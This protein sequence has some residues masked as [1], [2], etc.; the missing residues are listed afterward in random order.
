MDILRRIIR[1][2]QRPIVGLSIFALVFSLVFGAQATFATHDISRQNSPSTNREPHDD[3][4]EAFEDRD[5]VVD[6]NDEAVSSNDDDVVVEA[7]SVAVDRIHV[8]GTVLEDVRMVSGTDRKHCRWVNGG[9]NSGHDANGNLNWFH[10][11]LRAKICKNDNSPTGWVKVA[12]GSTGRKCF[13]PFKP[14]GQPPGK[15]VKGKVIMVRSFER[16]NLKV[17]AVADVTVRGQKE[18]PDGSVISGRASARATEKER[19]NQSML[20]GGRGNHE[21][22][23]TQMKQDVFSEAKSR[24]EAKLVLD[25]GEQTETKVKKAVKEEEKQVIDEDDEIIEEPE[26]VAKEKPETI[27]ESDEL[28]ASQPEEQ[29]VDRGKAETLPDTGPGSILATF[30]GA[31][32]LSGIIYSFV[33]RRFGL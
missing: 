16:L 8:R 20:S 1:M 14:N 13:N 23:R 17:N 5:Q 31:S 33:V 24:A 29:I 22:L 3:P 15:V 27:K 30:I 19:I 2:N 25:C 6:E 21:R 28:V 32:S 11:S 9:F 4:D 12:G 7:A 10:D 26:V 18:C